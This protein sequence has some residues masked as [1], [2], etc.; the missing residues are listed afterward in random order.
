MN[1]QD[2][3][4]IRDS[5]RGRVSPNAGSIEAVLYSFETH[6]VIWREAF[7]AVWAR[8]RGGERTRA[9]L[10][11]RSLAGMI[12]DTHLLWTI[13]SVVEDAVLALIAYDDASQFLSMSSERLRIWKELSEHPAAALLLPAVLAMERIQ[14]RVH[15]VRVRS[16]QEA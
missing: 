9:L 12:I 16:H 4:R 14:Q 10:A 13:T 15:R 6:P 2:I 1:Q 5:I 11:A 7:E 3:Q 8:S